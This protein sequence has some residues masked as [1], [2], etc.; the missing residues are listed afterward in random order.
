MVYLNDDFAGG[1][2]EFMDGPSVRP[3]KG[4]ALLFLHPVLHQGAPVRSGRKYVLRRDVMYR[5]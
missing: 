5:R 1:D 4:A 2:T 3:Q